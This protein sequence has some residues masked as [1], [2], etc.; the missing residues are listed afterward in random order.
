MVPMI[1]ESALIPLGPIRFMI[2]MGLL[3]FVGDRNSGANCPN[4]SSDISIII[5]IE[6]TPN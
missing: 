2:L 5:F 3:G 1:I 6:L 4:G